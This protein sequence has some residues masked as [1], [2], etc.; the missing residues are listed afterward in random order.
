VTGIIP[1]VRKAMPGAWGVKFSS[2]ATQI[3]GPMHLFG[4]S[5]APALHEGAVPAAAA[6]F[7][8]N[9]NRCWGGPWYCETSDIGIKIDA[10]SNGHVLGP[11]H[12][13]TCSFGNV[14]LYGTYNTIRDFEITP[15]TD[16]LYIASGT[17]D[18]GSFSTIQ[19]DTA[20]TSFADDGLNGLRVVITDGAGAGQSRTIIDYDGSDDRAT[21]SPGWVT[22]PE[23]DSE[24]VIRQ[25]PA[26]DIAGQE[27]TVIN[28]RIGPGGAVPDGVVAVRISGSGT[29]QVIRDLLIFGTAGSSAPLIT[30]EGSG[31]VTLKNSVIVAHCF[32]AG[33]FLDL[34]PLAAR[35]TSQGGS[36][37]TIELAGFENFPNDYFKNMTV[38]I[39]GGTGSG[40]SRTITAYVGSTDTAT[41][42]SEW[43]TIPVSGNSIYEIRANRIGTG[44]YIWLTTDGMVTTT[45]NLPP[46][47]NDT[48]NEIWVDGDRKQSG[49]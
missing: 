8:A 4:I 31:F 12:S 1:G 5:S 2:A 45:V 28:G 43:T 10:N 20:T 32:Q 22:P 49:D 48:A 23:S 33:T 21:V 19:L 29:R 16:S 6:W 15:I 46:S 44:N 18:S 36:A 42:S 13:H 41:V 39:V 25:A 47:W 40:Q 17:A 11:V 30:V 7:V 37:S 3:E 24:Y 35:G 34:Y 38:S 9:A 27:N 26:I 14:Q